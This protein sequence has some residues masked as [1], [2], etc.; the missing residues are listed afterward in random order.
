MIRKTGKG[1][2]ILGVAL[3]AAAVSAPIMTG[4]AKAADTAMDTSMSMS[5]T[6]MM[7]NGKV[8][9]YWTDSSGYVTAVDVQTA[10]GPAVIRFAPGQSMRTMQMYPV[11]STADLWVKGSMENGVQRW[12]LVGMGA[13]QP[14]SWYPTYGSSSLSSLM[15][16]PYVAGDPVIMSVA[17]KLKKVIVNDAGQVA[18]LV[19]E[20][21]WLGKGAVH[22]SFNGQNVP[23]EV[24]WKSGSTSMGSMANTG[25][26]GDTT[27]ASGTA[28]MGS[29]NSGAMWTVIRVP[30][31]TIDAPNGHE[32]M[33][34]KTPL[35]VNDDIEATGYVEAPLY[36]STSPYGQRFAATG[37]SVNGR[38]VGQMGFGLYK[39]NVKTLL[40]FDLK[41]PFITGGSS[42]DLPIVPMGYEA[43]NQQAGANMSM[44]NAMMSK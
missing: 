33:R 2:L 16:M 37:L 39:P 35:M 28:G 34:R 43:Y 15:A 9:N 22:R 32:G 1:R 23:D 30:I 18:G 27:S 29:M 11:G 36:G 12:D 44:G 3:G 42:N 31:E 20:T 24:I 7:V 14:S 19:V 13:T 26:A 40:N 6:P 5:S 38:G 8:N 10:N 21:T 4:T 25:A 41:I 17:G